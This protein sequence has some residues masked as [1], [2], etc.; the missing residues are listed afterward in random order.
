MASSNSTVNLT[1]RITISSTVP[2]FVA[3]SPATRTGRIIAYG[4]VMAVSLIA[5]S[6]II[7]IVYGKNKRMR[8]PINYFIVNIACCDL[9]L[10]IVYMPRVVNIF[11]SGYEWLVDGVLGTITC[12]FVAFAHETAITVAILTVVVIS[13]ERFLSLVFPFKT[14]LQNRP[15]GIIIGSLWFVAI[16]FRFPIIYAIRLRTFGVRKYCVLNL[17]QTFKAGAAKEYY[18][19]I[20]ILL[21]GFPLAAI[22]FFYSAIIITLHK[23]KHPSSCSRH[24]EISRKEMRNRQ[25]VRM[26]LIVIAVF[27]SCWILYFIQFVLYTYDIPIPCEAMFVRIF[28]A[29]SNCAITPCLYFVFSENYRHGLRHLRTK[30]IKTFTSSGKNAEETEAADTFLAG[31]SETPTQ[32]NYVNKPCTLKRDRGFR[33]IRNKKM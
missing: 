9:I 26:I 29:H 23:Q 5:N 32:L 1:N 31:S 30:V 8:K 33:G 7:A 18:Q 2:C 12:K 6:V 13:V 11:S 15:S 3:D 20:V 28:L 22:V 4:A 19:V 14:L 27:I 21:Y 24:R 17:D 10:S 25:V 16:A